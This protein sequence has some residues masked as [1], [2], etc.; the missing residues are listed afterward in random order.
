MERDS[1]NEH[2]NA[3]KRTSRELIANK[4][5]EHFS[6]F[7]IIERAVILELLGAGHGYEFYKETRFHLK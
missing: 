6:K 7:G 5:N 2:D 1:S 4:A 3:L